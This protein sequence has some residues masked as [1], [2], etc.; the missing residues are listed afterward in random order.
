MSI[1]THTCYNLAGAAV[2]ILLS[3]VTIPIY[4]GA[5]GE[6]RYGI[7]AIAWLL[8]GYFSLFDLGMGRAVAQRVASMRNAPESERAQAVWTALVFTLVCGTIGGLLLWLV[9]TL[10]FE[11]AFT[12]TDELRREML[13]AAGWMALGIPLMTVSGV[14]AGAL[15]GAERFRE[16]NII[17][18]V[19]SA[20]FQLLP[21]MVALTIGPDLSY[22]LPA[23]ILARLLSL[24]MLFAVCRNHFL[25]GH[26][27]A[28]S[29]E[30]ALHLLRFGGWVTVTSV[31]GPIMVGF[32]RLA[33][34]AVLGAKAVSHYS[35][36]FQL[37]ERS[38]IIPTAVVSALLPRL[39][40]SDR[41]ET[42]RL[43][44]EALSAIGLAMTPLMGVGIVALREFLSVWL[45]PEFASQAALAGQIAFVGFWLNSFAKVPYMQLLAQKLPDIVA[46]CH[47]AEFVPYV[48]ALGVGLT[49]FG[50]PGAAAAFTLRVML[51]FAL[52]AHFAGVLRQSLRSLVGPFSWIAAAFSIAVVP[53]D[54][55]FL[56][57]AIV[58]TYLVAISIWTWL[59]SPP[60]LKTWL[61]A[62]LRS[63]HTG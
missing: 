27:I 10:S 47:L 17:V 36:P 58:A 29:V 49:L 46:K 8:M 14:L 25:S 7:L 6:A 22:L 31:I 51:D 45:S 40:G 26:P 23:A 2:P 56:W 59:R 19:G 32:D 38:G 5:I 57:F 35:V 53:L 24:T 21:L 1:R 62:A 11:L 63:R 30:T 18:A 9:A 16:L 60:D 20:L 4:I 41:V 54:Q 55:G 48:L 44:G 50:L 39:A 37:A 43:A 3:L 12:V 13:N 61:G 52:L 28:T 15:Q 33:I 42:E 34:G